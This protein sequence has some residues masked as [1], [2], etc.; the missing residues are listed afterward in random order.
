MKKKNFFLKFLDF[1]FHTRS[2]ILF[3]QNFTTAIPIFRVFEKKKGL[4]SSPAERLTTALCPLHVFASLQCPRLIFRF[5]NSRQNYALQV[6]FSSHQNRDI[7]HLEAKGNRREL[8]KGLHI[9][10][11]TSDKDFG[12]VCFFLTANLTSRSYKLLLF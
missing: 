11:A 4:M 5:P 12:E 3:H 10:I 8:F 9:L 6:G 1:F 2:V 7:E